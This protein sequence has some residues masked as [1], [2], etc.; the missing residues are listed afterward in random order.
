MKGSSDSDSDSDEANYL[1]IHVRC[2]KRLNK[3]SAGEDVLQRPT[4]KQRRH[5]YVVLDSDDE[6]DGT[7]V[8]ASANTV[9]ASANT[10]SKDVGT[11]TSPQASLVPVKL[12]EYLKTLDGF[13][14]KELIELE[15]KYQQHRSKK[16][17]KYQILESNM[18]DDLKADIYQRWHDWS[19][20]DETSSERSG[21]RYRLNVIARIPW[22]KYQPMSVPPVNNQAA[23]VNHLSK[24]YKSLHESIFGQHAAK[25]KLIEMFSNMILNPASV[26]PYILLAGPPGIGKTTLLKEAITTCFGLKSVKINLGGVNDGTMLS[27]DKSLWVGSKEGEFARTFIQANAMNVHFHFDEVDDIS[28]DKHGT[29]LQSQLMTVTDRKA[30]TAFMDN[31]LLV[32]FDL[33]RCILTFT[34]NDVTKLKPALLSR[35]TVIH[36]QG[37]DS[38][39]KMVITKTHVI[40]ALLLEIHLS[41]KDVQFDDNLLGEVI[42]NDVDPGMRTVVH[43]L[44]SIVSQLGMLL[45]TTPILYKKWCRNQ[46]KEPIMSN[47]KLNRNIS[48]MLTVRLVGRKLPLRLVSLC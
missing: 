25:K 2:S 41:D 9:E 48:S 12:D 15:Q 39:E 42:D 17:L 11:Q 14:Q 21:V 19:K 10:S 26:Q 47:V 44:E 8:E 4:K 40:P 36:L 24:C 7:S 46:N 45:M 22:G 30:N 28:D 13:K 16:P 3:T 1:Q 33:S 20:M 31:N 29:D 34:A 5:R 38:T 37:Y 18:N 35:M 23:V 6:M 32:P 27:G 43:Q